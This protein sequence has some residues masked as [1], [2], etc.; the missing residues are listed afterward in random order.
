MSEDSVPLKSLP[1]N[2]PDESTYDIATHG[3]NHVDNEDEQARLLGD[4]EDGD[5]TDSQDFYDESSVRPAPNYTC[6]SM[7][8]VRKSGLILLRNSLTNTTF[9]S[10]E[11]S[12]LSVYPHWRPHWC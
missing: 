3:K 2:T 4:D 7:L 1:I 11:E 9:F 5:D 12:Y 6:P 8:W 10:V